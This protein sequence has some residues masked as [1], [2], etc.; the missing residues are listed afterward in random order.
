MGPGAEQG[1]ARR[2]RSRELN[3][4]S[5]GPG[6][7]LHPLPSV[8]LSHQACIN[9]MQ[10]AG[11]VCV[12]VYVW[13]EEEVCSLYGNLRR[14]IHQKRSKP[15]LQAGTATDTCMVLVGPSAN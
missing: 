4:P 2:S 14:F 5:L 1:A 10:H 11:V 7:R 15:L 8:R 6:A 12:H 13:M 9:G 3:F